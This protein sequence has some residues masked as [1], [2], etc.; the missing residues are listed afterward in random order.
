MDKDH[1]HAGNLF[2]AVGIETERS[3]RNRS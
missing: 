2:Q 3:R 1:G